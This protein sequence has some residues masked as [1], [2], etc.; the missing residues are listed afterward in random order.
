MTTTEITANFFHRF[1]LGD[2]LD[3]ITAAMVGDFAADFDTERLAGL[4]LDEIR[5]AVEDLGV[6]VTASGIAY[7]DA[8]REVTDQEIREALDG[9][10]DDQAALLDAAAR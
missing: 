2:D 7:R 1:G 5:A 6:T 10:L 3:A 9:V 8:A 4:I